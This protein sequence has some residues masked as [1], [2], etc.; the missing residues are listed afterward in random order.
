MNF[1][2]RF[3][4]ISNPCSATSANASSLPMSRYGVFGPVP[5]TP[6]IA[7]DADS[8][9]LMQSGTSPGGGRRL[10]L[11]TDNS[12]HTAADWFIIRNFARALNSSAV[13]NVGKRY[14]MHGGDAFA[15]AS[16]AF[17][18]PRPLCPSVGMSA[19]ATSN[20]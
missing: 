2:K 15:R 18:A 17:N 1:D 4:T 12:A 11:P 14:A 5:Q 9:G 7:W 19:S 6:S 13:L 20:C 3:A 10:A 8:V 16:H